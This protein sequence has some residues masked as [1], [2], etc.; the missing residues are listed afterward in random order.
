MKYRPAFHRKGATSASRRQED[1]L[2][3]VLKDT[4]TQRYRH[5]RTLHRHSREGG[6]PWTVLGPISVKGTGP[7]PP[8]EWREGSRCACGSRRKAWR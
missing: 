8:R 3:G 5:S 1:C 6:N 7:P 4:M 2:E